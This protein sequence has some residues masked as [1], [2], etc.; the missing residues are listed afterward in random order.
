MYG[1]STAPMKAD[2]A[3]HPDTEYVCSENR[4][5][6]ID[7]FSKLEFCSIL[8]TNALQG[9]REKTKSDGDELGNEHRAVKA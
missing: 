4:T 9:K 1:I 5:L 7:F 2:T 8:G 3:T 6:R